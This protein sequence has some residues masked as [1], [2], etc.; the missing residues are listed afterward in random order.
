MSRGW[1]GAGLH[2][3]GVY[4]H[5]VL[6]RGSQSVETS[7]S[8]KKDTRL[9]SFTNIHSIIS[10]RVQTHVAFR[11]VAKF[12]LDHSHQK[13]GARHCADVKCERT[14]P[15]PASTA[16]Q[17]CSKR[18][19]EVMCMR[20]DARTAFLTRASK[21]PFRHRER[22]RRM[23]TIICSGDGGAGCR[24]RCEKDSGGGTIF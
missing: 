11:T 12:A 20:L 1:F 24:R 15:P 7:G 16:A 3:S 17:T 14:R 13:I 6:S 10:K 18:L 5:Q 9:F 4:H 19:P 21:C 2:G 23:S 8:G 22:V